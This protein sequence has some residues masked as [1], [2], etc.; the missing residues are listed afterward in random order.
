MF[1]AFPVFALAV[2]IGACRAGPD[3]PGFGRG[4]GDPYEIVVNIS[5]AAPDVPPMLVGDSLH[6]TVAYTGGCRDH[7]FQLEHRVRQDTARTWIHHD[8]RGD[9]CEAY[10]HDELVLAVPPAVLERDAIVLLNPEGG[11]PHILRWASTSSP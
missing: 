3:E 8:A 11:P 5:P 4:F 9:P 1:R 6:V 7:E 2:A 10:L